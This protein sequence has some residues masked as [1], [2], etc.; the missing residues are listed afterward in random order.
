MDKLPPFYHPFPALKLSRLLPLLAVF[1]LAA[2][3]SA[4]ARPPNIV[5]ILTDDQGYAD[6]GVFGAKGF[7]TPN[8]DRM[9]A[10]G[11]K[12]TNFHVAQPVCSAS[13]AALLTG[14][15]PNRI[16]IHGA[17]G[18]RD[19]HGIADTEMT[20]AQLVKQKGYATAIM[21]K[22]HLGHHPQFLP[23]RHGFDEYFGLPY[24]ND[25]W[26]NHP[27]AKPGTFPELPLID[28][29]RVLIPSVTHEDQA[30]LTTW[31]TERAVQFI[32]KNKDQPFFLYVAHNMPH[33][34]LHV[35]DKFKGKSVRG[36]YG[37]VI[38]EID[39]SVGE[40]LSALKKNG[41]DDNTFVL[42]TS[43]NGPWLSYGDHAGSAYPLREGKGTNWE[44]GTREPCIMRW[45]EKIPAGTVC[46]DMLM[47]I[48]L[49]PTIAKWIGA[50]LPEHKIDGLDVWPIVAGEPGAKNPHDAYYF[51]YEVNQLQAVVTGDGRWK[52]QLPHT[53]RTLGGRPG[54]R[55]GHPVPYENRKLERAE[56]YDLESD[57][58]ETGD[59]AAANPET[60]QRLEIVAEQARDD[61]GDA[62]TKREGSGRREP[63]RLSP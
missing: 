14:C 62:L 15:Y 53:Y 60:V 63:G 27:E 39:W 42:F 18:P 33:V 49:F 23:T 10:E 34:P 11:R 51:Y 24:S 57:K 36:L 61:L 7:V 1:T 58:S 45:P 30:Q 31:Y 46:D 9:A 16:G 19:R 55:D 5:I 32:E 48:D 29:D 52:L 13:R 6:V 41:L 54:G 2:P 35:S 12:F 21:G 38:E 22:W 50:K 3:L 26:P 37:D 17:L 20:L 40:I 8:L 43:D 47:T 28:N 4:T 44:G 25:M 56:L 59:V